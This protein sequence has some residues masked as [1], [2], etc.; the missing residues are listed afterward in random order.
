MKP[1]KA[2]APLALAACLAVLLLPTA[3]ARA[4]LLGVDIGFPRIAFSSASP[5]AFNYDSGSEL[6]TVTAAPTLALFSS[7]EFPAPLSGMVAISIRARMDAG[8]QLIGGVAGDDFTLSGTVSRAV[9]SV[10]KTYTGTLLTGEITAF[11]F[12]ES[13]ATDQFD[14]RFAGTGGSLL[15]LFSPALLAA[16][17]TSASSSFTGGFAADFSGQANGIVG[18]DRTRPVPDAAGTLPLLAM[19][20]AGLLTVVRRP[21]AVGVSAS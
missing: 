13:G 3:T 20:V 11:G 2:N 19:A 5:I 6:L 21:R 9:G 16:D 4:S 17:I 1:S 15:G 7:S 14:F 18:Q 8:G 10:T 12:L